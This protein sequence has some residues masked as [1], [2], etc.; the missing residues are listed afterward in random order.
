M[1]DTAQ[2]LTQRKLFER[3]SSNTAQLRLIQTQSCERSCP[4]SLIQINLG[5][6]FLIS[7]CPQSGSVEGHK[8]QLWVITRRS[9]RRPTA[10]ALR[11]QGRRSLRRDRSAVQQF[12]RMTAFRSVSG[13]CAWSQPMTVSGRKPTF[14][15]G[16]NRPKTAIQPSR[17]ERLVWMAP[18]LQGVI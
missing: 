6:V 10:S 7:P 17:R 5:V 12:A 8:W 18:A 3:P 13:P 9:L 16:E 14:A 2:M 11:S 15:N 4:G 1:S